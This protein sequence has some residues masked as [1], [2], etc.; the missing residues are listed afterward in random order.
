MAVTRAQVEAAL[1]KARPEL[2]KHGG[3]VTLLGVNEAGVVLVRL[4]GACA[5]CHS[6]GATLH[7]VIEATL[8]AELPEITSVQAVM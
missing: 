4:V 6:A 1:D 5:G 8:K 3:N 2:I 7:N